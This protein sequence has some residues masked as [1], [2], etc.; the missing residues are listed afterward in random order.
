MRRRPASEPLSTRPSGSS[1]NAATSDSSTAPNLPICPCS[2]RPV[3]VRAMA[4]KRMWPTPDDSSRPSLE[5]EKATRY[6]SW[7]KALVRSMMRSCA[8]S[9]TERR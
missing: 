8:Q 9:H 6:T 4:Q 7:L 3:K 1:A 2:F 5:G